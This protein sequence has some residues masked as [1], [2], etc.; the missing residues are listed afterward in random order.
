MS[1]ASTDSPLV[2]GIVAFLEETQ[3]DDG[4]WRWLPGTMDHPAAPWF[5][6]WPFPSLNPALDLSG[7]LTRLGLGSDRLHAHCRTI[8][9][10][11]AKQEEITD[12]DFYSVLPYAESLPWLPDLPGR[13]GHLA[14]LVDK[15][16]R[17]LKAVAYPAPQQAIEHVGPPDGPVA[18]RL[19]A[20]YGQRL[21]E[22]TLG[23]QKPDGS[24]DSPYDDHWRPYQTVTGMKILVSYAGL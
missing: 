16:S 20:G 18:R 12:G 5:Q 10:E 21:V 8:Y 6:Q 15:V 9:G 24:W 23:T 4:C 19:P 22:Q 11:L 14:A 3:N 7:W 17:D 1:G 2:R 13:D